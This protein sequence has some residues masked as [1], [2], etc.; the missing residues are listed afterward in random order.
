MK[1]PEII[2]CNKV[3]LSIILFS[4]SIITSIFLQLT[5]QL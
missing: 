3:Y 1:F 2:E 5:V 4:L